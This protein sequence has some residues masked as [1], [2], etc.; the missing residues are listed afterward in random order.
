[1]KHSRPIALGLFLA[2]VGTAACRDKER[3]GTT[4]LTGSPAEQAPSLANPTAPLTDA[5]ILQ[6]AHVANAGEIAQGKLALE[7]ATDPRVKQLATMMVA[8]HTDADA[9]GAALAA[10][11]SLNLADSTPSATVTSDG[12]NILAALKSKTGADFDRAYVDAQVTE[13]K[14]VLSTLD[15][16]LIP[17]AKDGQLQTF[18]RTIRSAIAEHLIHAQKL[19]AELAK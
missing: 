5:Q 15:T 4:T 10:K 12:E 3:L 7:K 9:K 16:L 14:Q 19:Q 6:V 17:D 2:L 18:V 1:M 13:H 11:E 8:D